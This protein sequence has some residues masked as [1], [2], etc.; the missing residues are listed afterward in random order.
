MR[1]GMTSGHDLFS[2]CA[3]TPLPATTAPAVQDQRRQMLLP[4][5]L[6]PV[7]M[8]VQEKLSE[9]CGFVGA[10]EAG[11]PKFSGSGRR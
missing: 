10:V 3:I 8:S 4:F 7:A 1:C 9:K 11:V 5:C 2:C 6:L